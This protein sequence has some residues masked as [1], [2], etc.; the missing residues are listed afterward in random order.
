MIGAFGLLIKFTFTTG[1]AQPTW[2]GNQVGLAQDNGAA[3]SAGSGPGW[4]YFQYTFSSV[5]RTKK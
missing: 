4:Q 5:L 3:E 2:L 1:P